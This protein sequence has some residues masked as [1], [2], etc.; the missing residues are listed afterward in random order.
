[1]PDYLLDNKKALSFGWEHLKN[2]WSFWCQLIL[3]AGVTFFLPSYLSEQLTNKSTALSLIVL[4]AAWILQIGLALGLI[5][6]ALKIND[7]IKP[8]LS[9][10]FNY[11]EFF[12]SYFLA[13]LLY[14]LIIFA[15][16]ILLVFPAFVWGVKY[17][18]FAY[19]IIDRKAKPTEA[20]QMSADATKDVKW[21]LFIFMIILAL[22]NIAGA[23][24]LGIGLFISIPVTYLAWAFVY[25]QLAARIKAV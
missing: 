4:I 20:L 15:G 7:Q 12:W 11:F 21:Q 9:D 16:I 19:F 5:G 1:M 6:I 2:N 13:S 25:R 22:I 3:I 14:S 17:S 23:M 24:L 8:T 18:L 10:L